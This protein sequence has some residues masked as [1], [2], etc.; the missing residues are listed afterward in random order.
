LTDKIF[1]VSLATSNSFKFYNKPNTALINM[2]TFTV[3]K[4][5]L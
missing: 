2:Y 4:N 3:Y 5:N 1:Y